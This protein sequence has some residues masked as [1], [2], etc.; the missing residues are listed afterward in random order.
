MAAK[1]NTEDD[2]IFR[3][4]ENGKRYAINT[5]TGAVSGLG[6]VKSIK[7]PRG[8]SSGSISSSDR[9]LAKSHGIDIDDT[10][11]TPKQDGSWEVVNPNYGTGREWNNN[12]GA[13][14][15]AYDM[16]RRGLNVTATSRLSTNV[17]DYEKYYE[18]GKFQF[19]GGTARK[20]ASK[21]KLDE[22]I[23]EM[24]DGARGVIFVE[25][26]GK[27]FGHFFN[28][29]VENGTISYIDPQSG[30]DAEEYFT[31]VKP[32]QTRYLRVDN[33]ALKDDAFSCVK[34]G[35]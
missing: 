9:A 3:T 29:E 8:G 35:S 23:L 21:K 18:G 14:V 26:D 12:C 25:W 2:V 6:G 17:R 28:F 15:V 10:V 13:C 19:V 22:T 1:N 32:S 16:R 7:R 5:R 34:K 11:R 4:A 24:G 33:L 20:A 27:T 30:K 31:R